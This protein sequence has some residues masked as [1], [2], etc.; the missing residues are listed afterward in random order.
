MKAFLR[1]I[2][3]GLRGILRFDAGAFRHFAHGGRGFLL[4]FLAAVA[5]LPFQAGIVWAG[6]V[7]EQVSDPARYSLFQW[8]AYAV[9][10]LA[11]PLLMV[12]I[13]R[14]FRCQGRYYTYFAAFNWFQVV[15]FAL[16]TPI[17]L[18]GALQLL[19]PGPAFLLW[20]LATLW[21]LAYEWFLLRRGLG[22]D[23]STATALTIINMLLTLLIYRVGELLS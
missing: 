16:M 10:W 20:L 6:R 13:A 9:A 2:A 8:L 12:P 21:L 22:V 15:E 7:S 5:V 23:M 11:Y 17:I 18:L 3:A 1:E 4:S 14:H 19:P